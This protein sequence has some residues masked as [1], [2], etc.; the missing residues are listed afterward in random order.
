M[1]LRRTRQLD[2]P[3]PRTWGGARPGAGRKPSGIRPDPSHSCRPE[4]D[5]RHPVHVTLRAGRG[6]PSLRS[7]A[8]FP[9]LLRALAAA[10]RRSFR[11][12]HFSVQSD[13][14]HLIVEGDG[15]QALARGLQ[16][17]AVRCARAINRCCG[18]KGPVWNGRYHART[19]GTPREVRLALV[20]V[21]LNFRKHLHAPPA[22][23]PRSSG[24]WFDGWTQAQP[25]PA[26][27]SPVSSPHTWLATTGW[28][29]A[30]GPIDRREAP[31]PP[32]RQ[33]SADKP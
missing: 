20:Y 14:I 28:R 12:L 24:P 3:A 22:V 5:A 9:E 16:G 17:L 19:L 7:D 23:D 29:R 2:L 26:E 6:V 27:P 25:A 13:H 31:A 1:A 15:A 21:L 8:I 30:G 32:A 33:K 11:L 18:H 10:S 4:H